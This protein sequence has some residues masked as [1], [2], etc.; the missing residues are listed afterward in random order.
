MKN[1]DSHALGHKI[2][3]AVNSLYIKDMGPLCKSKLEMAVGELLWEGKD[4][5]GIHIMRCKGIFK[6][7]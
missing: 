4:D 6:D 3:S 5:Y 1:N 2:L 7:K